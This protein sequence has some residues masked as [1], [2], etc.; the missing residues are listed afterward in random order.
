MILVNGDTTN[1]TAKVN[2]GSVG[3]KVQSSVFFAILTH[4][5]S[6]LSKVGFRYLDC[7]GERQT[8]GRRVGV[9]AKGTSG[10]PTERYGFVVR[11]T[12]DCRW[13]LYGQF[14]VEI[15]ELCSFRNLACIDGYG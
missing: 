9:L 6:I 14:L 8:K 12:T 15:W 10:K 11:R 3:V 13:R 5:V 2:N 4:V 1:G 7:K